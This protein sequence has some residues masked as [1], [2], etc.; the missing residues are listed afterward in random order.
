MAAEFQD[1]GGR[2]FYWDGL[3]FGSE[4]EAEAAAEKYAAEGF[5]VLVLE[6]PEG[7]L[8]YSRREAQAG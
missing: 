3:T 6:A 4:P 2:R 5:E 1:M 7:H 8:V